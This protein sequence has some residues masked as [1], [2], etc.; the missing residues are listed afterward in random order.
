MR[1]AT[2]YDEEALRVGVVENDRVV[3]FLGDV[4]SSMGQ[5]IEGG[6]EA[7]EQLAVDERSARPLSEVRLGPAVPVPRNIV[8]VGKNYPL[9]AVEEGAD[10]PLFPLLFGKH[11]STVNG[12]TDPIEWDPG[13][14]D[15]VDWEAEL[16]V[17]IGKSARRVSAGDALDHVFGYTA[18]NDVSSRE[19]QFGDGQWL[20][21]KS[22]ETFMPIGPVLVTPYELG[23]PQSLDLECRVNGVVK[24]SGN[25]AQMYH[26]VA[27]VIS[28]CSQ[29]F[30]LLPGDVILTGTPAGVGVFRDPPEFLSDGDVVEVEIEGIGTLRNACLATR[31]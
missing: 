13:Y 11:T 22:L 5:L 6:L 8:C 24:Q 17:V 10:V 1:F 25:T 23:D 15:Q 29:A 4:V 3:P 18:A 27:N 16:V 30:T 20:R 12:P 7:A 31:V 14:T 9:H 26:P 21:G 28:Y 19:I 2:Y